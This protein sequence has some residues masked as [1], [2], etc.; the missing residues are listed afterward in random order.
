MSEVEFFYDLGS[1]YAW[2]SAERIDGLFDQPP[3]W[4]PVLL[5]GIFKATGRSSWAETDAR[6]EGIAEVERRAVSRGLPPVRWAEPWPNDGLHVMRVAAHA[7]SRK[8]ALAAFRAHFNGARALSDPATVAAIAEQVGIEPIEDKQKLREN[9]DRALELG[10]TGVPSVAVGGQ[11]F[12][13]DDRVDDA[14]VS[15]RDEQ[16]E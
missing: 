8:F 6:A 2:L 14:A 12:F 5:G 13:G 1:P 3:V 7:D 15:A 4:T 10:V 9:T 16:L 11:V